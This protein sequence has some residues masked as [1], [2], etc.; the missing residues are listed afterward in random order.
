MAWCS[1]V[2][3][4]APEVP[5]TADAIAAEP[6]AELDYVAL[7]DAATLDPADEVAGTQRLLV[8]ARFGTTRLLDNI[9]VTA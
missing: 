3:R 9:A 4:A 6:E 5:L 1:T 2:V 7:V 8:A